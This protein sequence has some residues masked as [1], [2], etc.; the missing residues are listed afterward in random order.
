MVYD[1]NI[2]TTFDSFIKWEKEAYNNGTDIL[3]C[4]VVVFDNIINIKKKEIKTDMNGLKEKNI[5]FMN[6]ILK[7]KLML[8]R[9]LKNYLRKYSR[10]LLII[11]LNIIIKNN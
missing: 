8:I 7:V 11:D 5:Y 10:K 3:K 1:S 2:K 9:L 6:V 4:V